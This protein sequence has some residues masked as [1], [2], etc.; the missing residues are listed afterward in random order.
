M[1]DSRSGRHEYGHHRRHV[2]IH[3]IHDRQKDSGVKVFI[4]LLK[5]IHGPWNIPATN[6]DR[7]ML[8]ELPGLHCEHRY[9]V[10]CP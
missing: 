6:A 10:I 7:T 9:T 1:I 4:D 3:A 2:A 8:I 5:A